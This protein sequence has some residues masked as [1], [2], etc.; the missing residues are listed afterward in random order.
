MY[1]GRL[2]T[3]LLPRSILET[4]ASTSVISWRPLLATGKPLSTSSSRASSFS[5]PSS[6]VTPPPRRRSSIPLFRR[7]SAHYV[8]RLV[9]VLVV[10]PLTFYLHLT[11]RT[12]RTRREALVEALQGDPARMGRWPEWLHVPGTTSTTRDEDRLKS[13]SNEGETPDGWSQWQDD[14]QVSF[15][16]DV[17]TVGPSPFDHVPKRIKHDD[18]KR[19]LFLTDY[20]DYLERMN[21]HT[22]EIVDAAIRH[23][24]IARLDVWGPKWRYWDADVPVSE[25]IRR[26]M[27]WI[28]ELEARRAEREQ[29][30]AGGN[31]TQGAEGNQ[32]FAEEYMSREEMDGW[33]ALA[34]ESVAGCPVQ[35]FD[36]VW[37]ISD[38]FK[39]TDPLLDALPCGALLAQQLGDCHSLNCLREWYPNVS[40]IT[41][42]KYGFEMLELFNRDRLAHAFPDAEAQLFGHSPDSANP[43]DFW[44]IPWAERTTPVK[45]FGFTGSFYPLRVTITDHLQSLP[46]DASALIERYQHPGY[47]IWEMPSAYEDPMVTY[48]QHHPAYQHHEALR[49]DFAK[50]MREAKI[51]VFDSS[52]ERKMIRKYAQALLAGCVVAGDI[53]TESEDV[54]SE[55]IIDL[56]PTWNIDQINAELARHLQDDAALETKAKLGFAYARKYLTN[57][58]KISDMIRLVDQYRSGARGYDL[59]NGFSLRCRSYWGDD[60]AW[61]PPWCT[62]A[63]GLEQ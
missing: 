39:Q 21:T 58:N 7:R 14:G 50:H 43:W 35:G 34:G 48:E 30:F 20:H 42:T 18:T 11:S 56:K 52:L 47:T 3:E 57:T 29:H 44:P 55:F 38:I 22:Y 45:M 31:S 32:L 36:L 12:M 23:P 8:A 61:R 46:P 37:T 13:R 51:C 28:R 10:I 6:L 4:L 27:W 53:P 2:S 40:N 62:G 63:R 25:N 5:G 54:L 16:G 49:E 41:V 26:R 1:R 19:V 15:W 9:L 33:W 59:P 17:D 24:H 60:E